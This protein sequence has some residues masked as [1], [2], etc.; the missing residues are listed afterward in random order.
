MMA[1][2]MVSNVDDVVNDHWVMDHDV[3]T[4]SMLS[5]SGGSEGSHDDY[6]RN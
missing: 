6:E 4:M 5:E 1:A 3:S 2:A